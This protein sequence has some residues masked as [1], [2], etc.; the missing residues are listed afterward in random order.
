MTLPSSM[1]PDLA[2]YGR[3]GFSFGFSS[4]YNFGGGIANLGTGTAFGSERLPLQR[5]AMVPFLALA[6]HRSLLVGRMVCGEIH[7]RPVRC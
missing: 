3:S 2:S 1:T 4:I 6:H 5:P 7:H